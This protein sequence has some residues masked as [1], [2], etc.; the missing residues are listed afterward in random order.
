ME[1]TQQL[2]AQPWDCI[3]SVVKQKN[4]IDVLNYI[5]Q[6]SLK[7][8]SRSEKVYNIS[9]KQ[10]C[11]LFRNVTTNYI[12]ADDC[13]VLLGKDFVFV[14]IV[15]DAGSEALRGFMFEIFTAYSEAKR[16]LE[17]FESVLVSV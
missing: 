14:P 7:F 9:E 10:I 15:V 3:L 11:E 12:S 2:V 5:E 16:L 17:Y 4:K 8:R 13:C 1:T 6:H